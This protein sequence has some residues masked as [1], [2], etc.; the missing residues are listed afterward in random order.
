MC[1]CVLYYC[2]RLS[3]QL[4]L[5]ISYHIISYHI[6]SYHI[7]SYHTYHIIS[8]H[9]SY[10]IIYII[11]YIYISYIYHIISYHIISYHII[12]YHIY[13][14]I[15]YHITS[16]HIIYISYYIISYHI[17]NS[18]LSISA[19]RD[20]CT[21]SKYVHSCPPK[22]G[23]H[24]SWDT[25]GRTNTSTIPTVVCILLLGLVARKITGT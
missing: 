13:H 19:E 9:I 12:S 24:F 22:R 5:T 10:H 23:L 20:S 2:H 7:I 17:I 16:Y 3:T 8:Y 21:G 4:Q 1:K 6:I 11:S 14:I 25:F 18:I 15:S